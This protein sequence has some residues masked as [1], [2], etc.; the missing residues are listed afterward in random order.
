MKTYEI[1]TVI[2]SSDGETV[3]LENTNKVIKS[4]EKAENINRKNEKIVY[5]TKTG[6]KYHRENCS[7]LNGKN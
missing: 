3:K 6:K 2:V 7:Y 1:G 5:I 4:E